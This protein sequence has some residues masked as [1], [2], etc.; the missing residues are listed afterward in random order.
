MVAEQRR[1]AVRCPTDGLPSEADVTEGFR[2]G[3]GA[4]NALNMD[5]FETQP[6]AAAA[7]EPPPLPPNPLG[8]RP[9][10]TTKDASRHLKKTKAALLDS[11]SKAYA[12]S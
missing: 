2:V 10:G 7:E 9:S 5:I 12:R 4:D 6:P 1:P 3:N 8:G 11:V